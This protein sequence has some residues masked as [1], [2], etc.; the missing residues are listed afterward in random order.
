MRLPDM[1]EQDRG[2]R[3]GICRALILTRVRRGAAVLSCSASRATITTLAC[4]RE[5]GGDRLADGES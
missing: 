2:D 5:L 4:A 1:P 3:S